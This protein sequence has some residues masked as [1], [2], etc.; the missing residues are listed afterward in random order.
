MEK[1]RDCSWWGGAQ[2]QVCGRRC[3]EI[4]RGRWVCCRHPEI[5]KGGEQDKPHVVCIE[6]SVDFEILGSGLRSF[7]WTVRISKFRNAQRLEQQRTV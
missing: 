3:L 4:E 2:G 6:Y 7:G 1:D 5:Y